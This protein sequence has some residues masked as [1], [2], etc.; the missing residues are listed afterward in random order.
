MM[1]EFIGNPERVPVAFTL[2]RCRLRDVAAFRN[3]PSE[4]GR[5]NVA[6]VMHQPQGAK[7]KA[8]K[9]RQ[10]SG[11]FTQPNPPN[12]RH[13]PSSPTSTSPLPLAVRHSMF[14]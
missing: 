13:P 8:P 5:R 3:D 14:W 11:L 1:T 4:D 9:Q 7:P 12:I 10:G 2:A 6:D